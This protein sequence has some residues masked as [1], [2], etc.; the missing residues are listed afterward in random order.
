MNVNSTGAAAPDVAVVDRA[1]DD[2]V[3]LAHVL[4]VGSREAQ[5]AAAEETRELRNDGREVGDG[6]HQK[7]AHVELPEYRMRSVVAVAD[8]DDRH[9]HEVDG[10]QIAPL[11]PRTRVG[12]H[13]EVADRLDQTDEAGAR[14]DERQQ[15][16]G[17]LRDAYRRVAAQH[18]QVHEDVRD[19]QEADRARAAQTRPVA[20]HNDGQEALR[21][22]EVVGDRTGR[23][24]EQELPARGHEAHEERGEQHRIEEQVQPHDPRPPT[25]LHDARRGQ[26]PRGHVG[27]HDVQNPTRDRYH[28][29]HRVVQ[30]AAETRARLEALRVRERHLD[31]HLDT[32]P[33][34]RVRAIEAEATGRA[35]QARHL[36]LRYLNRALP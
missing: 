17:D 7:D 19:V 11:L 35:Q 30:L 2:H 26:R 25:H 5:L 6:E 12:R 36:L 29:H 33:D 10:F 28:K 14:E 32:P 1:A 13:P 34:R 4:L 8:G 9:D 16:A 3:P 23:E 15:R 20:A 18:V 24:E 27:T 31:P 21:D 22:R